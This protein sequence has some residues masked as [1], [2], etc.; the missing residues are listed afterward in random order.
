[1]L[2]IQQILSKAI[3]YETVNKL[4][5]IKLRRKGIILGD[6]FYY[7]LAYSK[8]N[9]TKESVLSFINYTN[10]TNYSRQGFDCKERNIPLAL[11]KLI[12]D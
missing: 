8:I 5:D 2:N 3:R 12:F 4:M 1:M 6:A 7:R 10:K 11:Y 9:V